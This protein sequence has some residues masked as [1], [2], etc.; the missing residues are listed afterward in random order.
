L[1]VIRALKVREDFRAR[2]Q[3]ADHRDELFQTFHVWL[4]SP[5]RCRGEP[6]N[7]KQKGADV[8]HRRLL[9]LLRVILN[10]G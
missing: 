8:S 2:L 10:K 6:A 7:K 4:P 5:R 1:L 3:R 9:D